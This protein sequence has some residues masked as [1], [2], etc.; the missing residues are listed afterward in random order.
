YTDDR[1]HPPSDELWP[2]SQGDSIGRWEGD[3]LVVDTVAIRSP[4]Y[5]PGLAREEGVPFVPMSNQ[6]HSVERIRMV[7]QNQMQ[8]QFTLEDP[9]A[10]A[11]PVNVTLNWERVKD[12]NRMEQNADDCDS[13]A[14]ERNPIVNGRY[15]TD[16]KSAPAKPAEPPK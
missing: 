6:L 12:I 11:K 13:A 7:N 14:T 15:T 4:V 8:I 16:V 5:L 3:M 2:M 9:V 1:P 10:L